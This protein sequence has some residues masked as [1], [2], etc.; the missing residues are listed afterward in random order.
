MDLPLDPTDADD[1][2]IR[3]DSHT[4]DVAADAPAGASP[5]PDLSPARDIPHSHDLTH[6]LAPTAGLPP[7][8][9]ANLPRVVN[10][11]LGQTFV[12]QDKDSDKEDYYFVHRFRPSVAAALELAGFELLHDDY[13][14]IYQVIS[15]YT[16]CRT[17]Y[18]LDVTLMI[19]VLRKLYAERAE[20]LSLAG[21][22]V[23]TMAELR[24]EYRT[25]TDKPRDLGVVQYEHLMRRM[26]RLG[27]V[28]PIDGRTIDVREGESR[29][30]LRGSVRMILPIQT[31]D[32]M[33]AWLRRFRG[34]AGGGG[35]GTAAINGTS[36][37][38]GDDDIDDAFDSDDEDGA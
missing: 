29:L 6:D 27:L 31:A 32:E 26:R 14:R 36:G 4:R 3:G 37:N 18:P 7:S 17:R 30:R 38:A 19:V 20:Q 9:R 10:R 33:A 35:S 12:Y 22:P 8:A 34:A 28:E 24:D 23:V 21:D 2:D 16:Y 25:I 5:A 1:S 13:H 11:L 15:R